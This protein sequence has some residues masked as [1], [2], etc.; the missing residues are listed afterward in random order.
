MRQIPLAAVRKLVAVL[1]F[2][3]LCGAQI[4]ARAS[5]L[6]EF[7]TA[8]QRD[9]PSAVTALALR[10]FDLNTRNAAGEPGLLLALR[11]ES[12]AVAALLLEHPG[13]DLQA[14]SP[15][16]ETALMMAALRGHLPL[17]RRLIE[18]GAAVN[19]PG[20]TA[21]HY[22]A[23][24]D[25]PQSIDIVR[26]L[27]EQQALINA[28]SPNRSTPLMMAAL[29]GQSSVV[30]L[31]LMRGANP[32]LKNEQGLTAIDFAHRADRSSVAEQIAAA[33]RARQPLGRW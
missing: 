16:G 26:L 4:S 6:D 21:L 20:W 1:V 32:L 18:R 17:V 9:R 23:S 8:I 22:A 15:S 5:S 2:V 28:E 31:L 19:Q 13:I 11:A 30:Q 7:F 33:A 24:S 3:A 27:L 14:R 10:G 12:F 25:A 29:Y